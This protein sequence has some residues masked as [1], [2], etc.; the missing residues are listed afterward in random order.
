MTAPAHLTYALGRT[1]EASFFTFVAVGFAAQMID[2]AL[3]MAYG[4]S[5]TALLLSFGIPPARASAAVHTAEVVVSGVSGLSHLRFGNVDR[6]LFR[7]LVLP[8]VAGGVVGAYVLSELPGERLR[9]FVAA[10]LLAMGLYICW[11][12]LRRVERAT[13]TRRVVPLGLVGGFFDAIGGGGWGP[14][15]TTTLIARGREPRMAI[16]SVNLSEFFVTLAQAATFVSMVGVQHGTVIVGL[17]VGGVIAAPF[18]AY[19][20]RRIPPK[21][22]MVAV[23][24]IIIALSIRNIAIAFLGGN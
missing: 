23:G 8:G 10:Y 14:I 16:G 7:R 6:A 3:G 2:G 17:V 21:I 1:V 11:R 4:V 9:P 15:V 18:A 5:S 20:C 12:A 13:L 24:V 19:L 22:L